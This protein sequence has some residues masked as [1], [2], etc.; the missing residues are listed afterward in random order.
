MVVIVAACVWVRGHMNQATD[1]RPAAGVEGFPGCV[2]REMPTGNLW[3]N[4]SPATDSG[5]PDQETICK[6]AA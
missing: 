4:L 2:P 3:E 1:K 5:Q 6:G